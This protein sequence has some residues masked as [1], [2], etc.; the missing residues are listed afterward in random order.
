MKEGKPSASAE[1]A[2]F[3][4]AIE[5]MKPEGER[6]CYDPVARRFLGTVLTIVTG[7]RLLT[8]VALWYRTRHNPGGPGYVT[9]RTR[10]IDDYLTECL[11]GGLEQLVILGAGYDSRAYR[12][13]GLRGRVRVFEVDHPATQRVKIEKVRKAFG[14]LPD[15]VVYVPLALGEEKLAEGLLEG[16]YRNDSKTLFI[17]E[18]VT[19][20]LS[21][22]AVDETLAFVAGNSGEGSSII[23]DYMYKALLDGTR[24]QEEAQKVQEIYTRMGEPFSFGVEEG[25]IAGFLAQ[26]GFHRVKDID[27]EFLKNAYF[28][29]VNRDKQVSRLGGI[30]HATVKR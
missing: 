8:K 2:V 4:R 6:V 26:R 13:D 9:A 30:V 29:G 16:G 18:G 3:Y 10:Y 7:S 12:F 27:G 11:E 5:S 1:I 28:Q 14:S 24:E 19:A 15:D 23:F 20:Y 21:G 17:C 22:E 25:T